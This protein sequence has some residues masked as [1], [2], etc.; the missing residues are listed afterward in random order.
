MRWKNERFFFFV[1]TPRRSIWASGRGVWKA[2]SSKND[3]KSA[4]PMPPISS[5]FNSRQTRSKWSFEM[6]RLRTHLM[7]ACVEISQ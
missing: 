7:S 5:T 4:K 3:E 1:A 2:G 6:R